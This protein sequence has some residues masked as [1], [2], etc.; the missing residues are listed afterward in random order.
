MVHTS[1]AAYRHFT[2]GLDP[3]T[4]AKLAYAIGTCMGTL[5]GGAFHIH[6]ALDPD[7]GETVTMRGTDE[8]GRQMRLGYT[9]MIQECISKPPLSPV[10]I[11]VAKMDPNLQP[12]RL[13]YM[14]RAKPVHTL[15][16]CPSLNW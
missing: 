4:G 7:G 11:L 6:L 1:T 3:D 14:R 2:R 15:L 10:R 8:H 5:P 16:T 13:S 9:L 12:G